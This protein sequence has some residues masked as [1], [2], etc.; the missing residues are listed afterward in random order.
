MDDSVERRAAAIVA[1]QACGRAGCACGRAAERGSGMTH[2]PAH[3]DAHPSL[4]VQA[5][6][7]RVLVRC[8]AGCPQAAVLAA[9][10]DAGLW[11]G[12]GEPNPPNPSGACSIPRRTLRGKGGA[13]A[14]G[15]SHPPS[16]RGSR[17]GGVGPSSSSP[18]SH[19]G[20]G[21][22]GVGH[23]T[24][25]WELRNADGALV[26]IHERWEGEG[27]KRFVW[28]RPD[29]ATAGLHGLAA[30]ALP[31]YGT[32]HLAAWPP[33]APL[34][35]V[36]GEKAADAAR[37]LGACALGTVTGAASA[38]N[39]AA[40]GPLAGRDVVLWP[41]ADAPGARHMARL[42]AALQALGA[43]VRLLRWEAAPAGGDAADFRAAGGTAEAL[44]AL[45][46]AVPP[47]T[48]SAAAA[49]VD[50]QGARHPRDAHLAHL[51]HLPEG[52]SRAAP[53]LSMPRVYGEGAIT[54]TADDR[55]V[56][57]L[58]DVRPEPVSWLWPDY[59]PLGKVI[60]LDGDPGLGKSALTL[61]LAAR[62][63]RGDSMPNGSRGDLD[64]PGNVV[65]LCGEDGLADTIRPR[66]EAAGADV[67]R[68][69]SFVSVREGIDRRL[70]T[71]PTDCERLARTIMEEAA[72]LVIID[73]LMAYLDASVNAHRDQDV[74]RA[75]APLVRMAEEL[76]TAILVVRHLTKNSDVGALYRGSGTI[77]IVGVAR[78]G[79]LVAADPDDATSTRRV[80]ASLKPNLARKAS[81]LI[82]HM[83]AA[84]VGP[85]DAISSVRVMWDGATH[86]TAESL[87]AARTGGPESEPRHAVAEAQ[88][89]LE[90]A[91]AGGPVAVLTLVAL[92]E[93]QGVR[94]SALRRA[95]RALGVVALRSG[96]ADG[97]VW[98]WALPPAAPSVEVGELGELGEQPPGM[99]PLLTF[100]E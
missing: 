41:D 81:S 97:L 85:D 25:R 56:L 95:K 55:D 23:P 73:P 46:A 49:Q 18:P 100:P 87:L 21:A 54:A 71:L 63:T 26:A 74:R 48:P 20:R 93:E 28:R 50:E 72:R 90:E 88:A 98:R 77:A 7:E 42:A 37:A 76:D 84:T 13:G 17:A 68:V 57:R 58:A 24:A 10:G 67:D 75:L 16:F 79:L 60:T 51:A 12:G 99:N 40:L 15:A 14:G 29:Y 44:A 62:V 69:V 9:L 70:V 78:S 64:G 2:C 36:E 27:G 34:L 66:L 22:G 6:A 35:V 8:H 91:L 33:D 83:E 61:D 32:E 4:H 45:L 80:F 59:V 47:W 1:R 19:S 30:A 94:E 38:P 65:L 82:Y 96:K 86:H 5:A 92:A 3:A 11:G 39:G 89:F 52:E 53:S 31:L 43:R